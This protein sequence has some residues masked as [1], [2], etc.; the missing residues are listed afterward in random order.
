[1]HAEGLSLN[2]ADE[3][4]FFAAVNLVRPGFIRTEAD[5]VHY[6]L[7]IM[8]RFD[9]ER[10]LMRGDLALGDLEA[11]WND[12]FAADFG[13][14]V[15]RPSNGVL[16]DVHWPVGLFGYFPTY[17]LGNVYAGSLY[18]ALRIAVP[19]LDGQLAKGDLGQALGWLRDTLQSH[20]GLRTPRATVEHAVGAAVDETALLG[21]LE[22]K[23]RALYG[24]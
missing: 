4:A 12:R 18:G 22:S 7:H 6:N 16:Q 23:Y 5:E 15:D 19:D 14:A 10:A 11:A 17:S 24:L 20:G 21:Y 8:L 9:L 2:L 1:M 3:N 13:M